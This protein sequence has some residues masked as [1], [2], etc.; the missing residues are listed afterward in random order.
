V[1]KFAA[2]DYISK[3]QKIILPGF[4]ESM[5]AFRKSGKL[6]AIIKNINDNG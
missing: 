1:E 3:M 2:K 4:G 6:Q 5:K